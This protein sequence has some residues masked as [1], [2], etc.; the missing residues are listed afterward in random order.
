M[1]DVKGYIVPKDARKRSFEML[2][3]DAFDQFTKKSI[4]LALISKVPKGM[5]EVCEGRGDKPWIRRTPSNIT[6]AYDTFLIMPNGEDHDSFEGGAKVRVID[7][8][9]RMETID[10]SRSKF[11][12]LLQ[13]WGS[14]GS[15]EYQISSLPL[16]GPCV[17]GSRNFRSAVVVSR[18]RPCVH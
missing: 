11:E 15:F 14:T 5:M 9:K 17:G 18:I 8:C 10:F 7:R 2:L 1:P 4:N 12:D 16:N 3:A 13:L 6:E